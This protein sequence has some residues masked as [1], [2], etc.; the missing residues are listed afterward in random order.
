MPIK[1]DVQIGRLVIG[2]EL[3]QGEYSPPKPFLRFTAQRPVIYSGSPMGFFESRQAQAFLT[4]VRG[5]ARVATVP[6]ATVIAP[7]LVQKILGSRPK[8]SIME[9]SSD[10]R[11]FADRLPDKRYGHVKGAHAIG[12]HVTLKLDSTATQRLNNDAEAIRSYFDIPFDPDERP[13][14]PH[15]N[16]AIAITAEAASGLA[17][18]LDAFIKPSEDSSNMP[19]AFGGVTVLTG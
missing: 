1:K 7:E 15:I 4:S 18:E 6:H 2:R 17:E 8:A 14:S 5:V 9:V 10:C 16:V 19:I 11:Q 3:K 12:K 13:F